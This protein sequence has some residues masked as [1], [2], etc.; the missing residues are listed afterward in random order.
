MNR[1]NPRKQSDSSTETLVNLN[2][3]TNTEKEATGDVTVVEKVENSSM[4]EIA[5]SNERIR[6]MDQLHR[7]LK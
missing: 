5:A 7:K 1:E 2:N 6:Q 3:M 4:A